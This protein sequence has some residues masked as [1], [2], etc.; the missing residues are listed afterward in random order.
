M[1]SH[2]TLLFISQKNTVPRALKAGQSTVFKARAGERYR[3]NRA[4]DPDAPAVPPVVVRRAGDDL[5]L[6]YAD[7]TQVILEGYFLACKE[8]ACDLTLP[9]VGAD[10][11]VLTDTFAPIAVLRDGSTLLYVQGGQEA[12]ASIASGNSS[13]RLALAEP[14]GSADALAPQ[15]HVIAPASGQN[16]LSSL[17]DW[18]PARLRDML[19]G[20]SPAQVSADANPQQMGW[21]GAVGGLAL[22]GLGGGGGGSGSA[23]S[24]QTAPT[25]PQT[26]LVITDDVDNLTGELVP[27]ATT[28]DARPRFSGSGAEVG[29]EVTLMDGA[30][31]LGKTVVGAN[32]AWT[33]TPSTPLADGM[34]RIS[35]RLSDAA[36]NKSPASTP[37]AFTVDTQ[38]PGALGALLD[39]DDSGILANGVDLRVLLNP[40]AAAG[41]TVVT[42]LM[43]DDQEV[44][45]LEQTLS[46]EDIA[47]GYVV[48]HVAATAVAGNGR[49]STSTQLSDAAGNQGALLLKAD[50]FTVLN[51]LVHDDYLANA[52][53]FVDSNNNGQW[54]SGEVSVRTDASGHFTLT[55]DPNGAPVLAM[56]GVD[57]ASG[58]PNGAVVYKAYSGNVD[59]QSVGL[60]IV[61]SPLSTLIAALADQATAP[62]Q[63]ASRED[64]MQAATVANQVL[65]LNSP[66]PLA[67]LNFDPVKDPASQTSSAG[68][69][70]L[71]SVNRQL[72]LVFAATGALLEG[73]SATQSMR[74]GDASAVSIASLAQM[75]LARN[76]AG[77][78]I[79]L[80]TS[81]D[82]KDLVQSSIESANATGLTRDLRATSD[83]DL[84]M[85]GDVIAGYNALVSATTQAGAQS[86]EAIATLRAAADLLLPALSQVGYE[87]TSDRGGDISLTLQSQSI[88]AGVGTN[89]Q[90]YIDQPISAANLAARVNGF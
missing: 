72:G 47:Q 69:R 9:S 61:L 30:L 81:N 36:G 65:G 42:R 73:A 10:G 38:A 32:G 39:P 28:N 2:I 43:R 51:G 84:Q 45:V 11:L 62:G 75:M 88:A 87:A 89:A 17:S 19:S 26:A 23:A 54:D 18:V 83:S 34:H 90:G 31:V 55:F 41:D 80:S 7:N 48:Q 77:T 4:E 82:I 64:L 37:V 71:L 50:T 5:R 76:E 13:L 40:Q 63:T 53:V 56:G 67:L 8:S 22:L 33:F 14:A 29:A 12:L 68:D 60:D 1:T 70:V 66:D 59:T 58:S 21:L 20:L 35:Y 52:F 79:S 15:S 85:L 44:Q 25:L 78:G 3:V 74:P 16:A 46:S 24:D 49:F 57:T 86:Q 6:D 27:Q